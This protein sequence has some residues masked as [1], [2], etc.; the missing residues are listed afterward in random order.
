MRGLARHIG[1]P[2]LA[3]NIL[4]FVVHLYNENL[5]VIWKHVR[6]RWVP[7]QLAEAAAEVHVLLDAELLIAEKNHQTIHQRIMYLLELLVAERFG[8]VNT[9]NFS[10]DAWRRFA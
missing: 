3:R 7:M 1:M 6:R 4:G 2:V 9:K 5:G 8:K 10:A